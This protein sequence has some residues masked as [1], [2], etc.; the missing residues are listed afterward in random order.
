MVNTSDIELL[1]T[2]EVERA[3]KKRIELVEALAEG[4]ITRLSTKNAFIRYNLHKKF[5]F[6]KILS[7][8]FRVSVNE[9]ASF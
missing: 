9:K 6:K 7:R 1:N 3:R 2:R 8:F 4:L 5:C